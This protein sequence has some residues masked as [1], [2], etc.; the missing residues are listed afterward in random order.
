M[1]RINL[2]FNRL[3]QPLAA[4]TS[5]CWQRGPGLKLEM[6]ISGV[7]ED[8]LKNRGMY[9]CTWK[10]E[11]QVGEQFLL[12]SKLMNEVNPRADHS[13]LP[14]TLSHV[15]GANFW[16]PLANE[17]DFQW[18]ALFSM[19]IFCPSHFCMSLSYFYVVAG[20]PNCF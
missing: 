17:S 10:R 13:C 2:R 6:G 5:Q 4:Q 19:C 15:L 18:F 11:E 9:F 16:A 20:L 7:P 1:G 12:F 14:P 3:S 8:R